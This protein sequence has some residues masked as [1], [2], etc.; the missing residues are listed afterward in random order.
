MTKGILVDTKFVGLWLQARS[1]LVQAFQ[2]AAGSGPGGRNAIS[3]AAAAAALIGDT[4]PRP[5][6][7]DE[8]AARAT[9]EVRKKAAAKGLN[10]RPPATVGPGQGL[11]PLGD[12]LSLINSGKAPLA[13][14]ASGSTSTKKAA[15]VKAA[16]KVNE[17]SKIE[18][19]DAIPDTVTKASAAAIVGNGSG[20]V[21]TEKTHPLGLG[22]GLG[23]LESKKRKP[24]SKNPA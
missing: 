1:D 15:A 11:P 2:A 18:S 6:G 7:Q 17:V 19:T 3:K 22:G 20:E 21:I 16:G 24:R 13:R 12:L 8:R 23:G 5:R 10:V 14:N 9:A 4:A